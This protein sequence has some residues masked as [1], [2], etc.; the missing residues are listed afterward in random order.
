MPISRFASWG[1]DSILAKGLVIIRCTEF[2]IILS[3]SHSFSIKD[4]SF[5]YRN[6]LLPDALEIR[7]DEC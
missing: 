6:V 2:L 7:I 4:R 1:Y 5:G 3:S